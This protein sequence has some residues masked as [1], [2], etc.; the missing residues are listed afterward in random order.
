MP[1]EANATG[2]T[3]YLTV[4]GLALVALLVSLDPDV[5]FT[6]PWAARLLFW[7][8]QIA[9]GLLV[10]Q[11][12]LYLLTRRFGASRMPSW[13]LV[14]LSA[15]FG[16]IVLAPL[17]WLIGE[18]LMQQWLGY[19]A[20]PDDDGSI[21]PTLGGQVLAEFFDI[22]IPVTMAW[23]LICLPRLHWLV[24]PLLHAEVRSAV[25]Q[26]AAALGCSPCAGVEST[27]G[28][29]PQIHSPIGLNV[30]PNDVAS[31]DPATPVAIA[32]GTFSAPISPS[33]CERLPTEMGTD[34]IAVAS[35]LQY[36]RVWTTRGCALILGTLAD[37]EDEGG[38]QGLRVHRSWWIACDHVI[39]VRRTA[40]GAVCLMSDGCEVPVS[41]RRRA[42]VLA[43]FGDGAKYRIDGASKAVP[44]TDL[45]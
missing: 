38:A 29:A 12:L 35:E 27:V 26:P 30:V 31:S 19:P 33:W 34:V 22:V 5:G 17:Y 32:A 24:P 8:L 4:T 15:V 14:L 23:A 28:T 36:L 41:R 21:S 16:S 7:V 25:S 10:L 2:I 37:V 44:H 3:R 39:S 40:T 43:R 42:E 18:G 6:A 13:A 45:H 20:R 11:S 9:S 1:I